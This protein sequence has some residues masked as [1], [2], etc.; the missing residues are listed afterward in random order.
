MSFDA[1][2]PLQ[3]PVIWPLPDESV[4][5]EVDIVQFGGT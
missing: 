4:K 5:Y 3:T 2:R 1:T